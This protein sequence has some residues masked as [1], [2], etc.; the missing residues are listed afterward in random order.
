L[1]DITNETI[2]FFWASSAMLTVRGS[3][4]FDKAG[5]QIGMMIGKRHHP[6]PE[7]RSE[8]REEEFIAV[9]R[10]G[11]SMYEKYDYK[12]MVGVLWIERKDGI[13]YRIDSGEAEEE[14][15]VKA[16]RIWKLIPLG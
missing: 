4:M 9:E 12:A 3:N 5:K 1:E 13:A 2:L 11:S 14:K 10:H 15:W 8:P 7:L 16:E 6:Y